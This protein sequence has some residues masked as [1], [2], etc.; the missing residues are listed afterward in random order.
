MALTPEFS[1]LAK[2]LIDAEG[3]T[4]EEAEARLRSM[5]LEIV[6]GRGVDNAA[7]H[8]AIL[9]AVAVGVKSFVGGVAVRLAADDELISAIPVATSSLREAVAFLGASELGAPA[10]AK[11]AIGEVDADIPIDA[12]AWWNG[13]E[14]GSRSQPV[15]QGAGDNPLAGIVAGAAA[16]AHAFA[17]LRNVEYPVVS[18]FD[19][20][21]MSGN[22]DAPPFGSTYLPG[23]IW[24]LGLGNLGQAIM[25]SLSALPYPN[26]S[27]VKLVLQDA[28]RISAE[29][30]GTSIL[31]RS[32]QYG[33]Y[34]TALSEAWGKK[35][36]LDIRRVDRWL[37]ERQRIG[38]GEP[39]LA[40]C[41]FD[42]IEARR[43]IDTCGFDVVIDAGLGRAH[44][45]FD[46]FRVTIFDRNHAAS[47]HFLDQAIAPAPSPH[48][49]EAL[50]GLDQCGAALFEGIGIAAP[51]VSSIAAATVVA[52][53]IAISSGAAV[54]RAEKRRLSNDASKLALPIAATARGIIRVSQRG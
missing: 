35:K 50:L 9:T 11:I 22:G 54:P 20:W 36:G 46:V 34:K 14:G 19:L 38:E 52:R 51:F 12:Y 16:V 27:Q 25:W 28:D 39:T 26:P 17:K 24:L 21:P 53:A 6:V 13:W 3:I 42:S 2:M 10:S 29:N 1:R 48:D 7:G 37:D 31:V 43:Q 5:T 30:W 41:G 23:S 40:V 47:A 44:T 49:Y 18:T 45:D 8:N 33:E 15:D 32:G 4:D